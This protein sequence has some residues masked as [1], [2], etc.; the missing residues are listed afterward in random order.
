MR[1]IGIFQI[2]EPRNQLKADFETSITSAKS[3]FWNFYN[4]WTAW[5]FLM[6]F[7][8]WCS[9]EWA[10]SFYICVFWG[11][12]DISA[13]A[14]RGIIL[15]KQRTIKALIRLCG[16]TGW[17]APL[18]FT[19]HKQVFL[20]R[21]SY[22]VAVTRDNDVDKNQREVKIQNKSIKWKNTYLTGSAWNVATINVQQ[23]DYHNTVH[24]KLY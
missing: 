6:R 1:Y 21:G 12:F 20:C 3:R 14:S 7:S 13:I 17:S 24:D 4:F 22:Y 11:L 2:M 9:G 8:L 19:C 10:L 18:L 16:C 15:S 23:N 5:N